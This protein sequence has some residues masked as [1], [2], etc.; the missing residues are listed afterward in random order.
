V[1]HSGVT[2]LPYPSAPATPALWA[3]PLLARAAFADGLARA[4]ASLSSMMDAELEVVEQR[5]QTLSLVE[6]AALAG[7]PEQATVGIYLAI[8]G[9]VGAHVILLLDPYDAERLVELM[10]TSRGI[11]PAE[12]DVLAL[13]ALAEVGNVMGSSFANVLGD[14]I[15][16]PLW[17]SSPTVQTDMARSL[18][19]GLLACASDERDQVL[20][21]ATQFAKTDARARFSVRGTFLVVPEIPGLA[22]LFEAL[23]GE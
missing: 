23:R 5:V 6:A 13:P 21:V 22:K 16:T 12:A 2:A 8:T 7:S 4:A 14:L 17:S 15:G 3:D 11:D 10:L 19:D 9:E 18:I 20:V 1:S